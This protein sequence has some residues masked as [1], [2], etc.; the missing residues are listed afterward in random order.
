MVIVKTG[1]LVEPFSIGW[2]YFDERILRDI[3]I[4]FTTPMIQFMM[5][6]PSRDTTACEAQ[7]RFRNAVV[8]HLARSAAGSA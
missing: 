4:G 1:T 6:R 2:N 3:Y 8:I 7:T 5:I